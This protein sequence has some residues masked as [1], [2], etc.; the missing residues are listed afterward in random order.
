[1]NFTIQIQLKSLTYQFQETIGE[2]LVIHHYEETANVKQKQ[3]IWKQSQQDCNWMIRFEL[4]CSAV[5]MPVFWN[6]FQILAILIE[7]NILKSR[8]IFRFRFRAGKKNWENN[9]NENISKSNPFFLIMKKGTHK[10]HSKVQWF[11]FL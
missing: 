9:S 6:C 11:S 7:N 3:N 5:I 10:V 4:H 8:L 2:I 1:M